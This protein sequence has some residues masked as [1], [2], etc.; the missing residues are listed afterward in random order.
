M[1]LAAG[2]CP[3]MATEQAAVGTQLHGALA[4]FGLGKQNVLIWAPQSQQR[5]MVCGLLV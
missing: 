3:V 2:L 4:E 1:T 5:K